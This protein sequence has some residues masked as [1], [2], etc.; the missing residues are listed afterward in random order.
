MQ[1]T[2]NI[3]LVAGAV[4]AT[5]L[6]K[7]IYW[8]TRHRRAPSYGSL[9]NALDEDGDDGS[10][11]NARP[12]PTFATAVCLWWLYGITC[13]LVLVCALLPRVDQLGTYRVLDVGADPASGQGAPYPVLVP[14]VLNGTLTQ[15]QWYA[16]QSATSTVLVPRPEATLAL[17]AAHILVWALHASAG[18]FVV[19]S[20]VPLGRF[21]AS[22]FTYAAFAVPL[23]LEWLDPAAAVSLLIHTAAAIACMVVLVPIAVSRGPSED[24][25]TAYICA[26]AIVPDLVT[27]F[28]R[29]IVPALTVFGAAMWCQCVLQIYLVAMGT[30]STQPRPGADAGAGTTPRRLGLSSG[31]AAA[32]SSGVGST[33]MNSL[34]SGAQAAVRNASR[35]LGRNTGTPRNRTRARLYARR[36]A[37]TGAAYP[38]VVP[39]T[40]TLGIV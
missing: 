20:F 38:P 19:T 1:S 11:K 16:L 30:R 3:S 26:L 21:P 6:V 31:S 2:D 13:G 37:D 32:S 29:F 23:A 8:T 12:S 14:A 35:V 36:R 17:F 18:L 10:Q 7:A 39:E 28:L 9:D 4:V 22:L 40:A 15:E 34:Q 5:V 33:G 24:Y 27:T 25:T